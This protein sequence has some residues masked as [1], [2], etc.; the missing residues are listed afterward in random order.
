MN[1]LKT[2]VPAP[3]NGP[4]QGTGKDDKATGLEQQEPV[5]T[6]TSTVASRPPETTNPVSEDGSNSEHMRSRSSKR[7]R[8]QLITS[9][10]QA[11]RA[12]K[13]NSVE[14]C[15]LASI[16]GCTADSAE[17]IELS[18]KEP[19]W[20]NMVGYKPQE[21]MESTDGQG[22]SGMTRDNNSREELQLGDASIISFVQQ[23]SAAN[24]GPADVLENFVAHIASNVAEVFSGDSG[25]NMVLADLFIECESYGNLEG[26][27]FFASVLTLQE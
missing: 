16:M 17:Y 11:E 12:A 27:V 5:G 13:R 10:K 4:A 14:Y 26:F 24:S 1:A 6:K 22:K 15:F 3:A 7:V 18:R 20:D 25:E 21:W 2:Q 9:G 23:W 19:P 8:S